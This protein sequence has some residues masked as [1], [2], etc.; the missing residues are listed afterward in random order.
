MDEEN[1]STSNL[2]EDDGTKQ[3]EPN[4]LAGIDVMIDE[5]QDGHTDA[6]SSDLTDKKKETHVDLKDTPVHWE[7]AENSPIADSKEAEKVQSNSLKQPTNSEIINESNMSDVNRSKSTNS[8]DESE[9]GQRNTNDINN[10]GESKTDDTKNN[11]EESKFDEKNDDPGGPSSSQGPKTGGSQN[12]PDQ[13]EYLDDNNSPHYVKWITWKG[14]KT[15]IVTQNDNGPCPLLAIINILLLRRVIEFPSMQE[16]VTTQQL[17]DYLGDVV[18]KEIPENLAEGAQRNFEQNMQDA[19]GI[20]PKLKTG[21][22]VNVRFTGVGEFEFTPECVIFDLLSIH[23]YHGW[24]VDPQSTEYKKA[25]KNLSY[26]QLV[27]KIVASKESN[28][29]SEL[30]SEGLLAETF[31]QDTANQLTYH[32]VCELNAKLNR[33]E[34]CVFFRNNHFSTLYKHKGELFLLL[35]DQGFLTEDKIVWQTLSNVDGS[36]VFVDCN[37]KSLS[38]KNEPV[39]SNWST[40]NPALSQEDQDYMLALSIQNEQQQGPQP[41]SPAQ[42]QLPDAALHPQENRGNDMSEQEFYDLQFA[43]QL[44][45]EEQA[46]VGVGVPQQHQRQQQRQQQVLQRRTGRRQSPPPPGV[47][48]NIQNREREGTCVIL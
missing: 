2:E 23:L 19:L 32:G 1:N 39:Q 12:E 41:S 48:E 3:L 20:L 29:D 14:M 16:M 31:L 11:V 22:D 9:N 33:D 26:N 6:V 21:L 18:L 25:I 10:S 15:A 8:T 38:M 35:T 24:L 46:R 37:F 42:P 4:T 17:M 27:E 30:S 7:H 28:E 40:G 43:R 44:H 34:L 5:S 36:G 13:N 47:H 45:Q